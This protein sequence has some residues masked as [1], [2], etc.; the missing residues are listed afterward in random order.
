M[1]CPKPSNLPTMPDD[2]EGKEEGSRSTSGEVIA[3]MS[4]EK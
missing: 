2:R 4:M 3:P 1:L